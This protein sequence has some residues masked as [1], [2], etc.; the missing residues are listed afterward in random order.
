MWL[1]KVTS[2]GQITI[3]KEVRERLDLKEQDRV[4]FTVDD[5]GARLQVVRRPTVAGLAGRLAG[6]FPY[7]DLAE[8][9]HEVGLALGKARAEEETA[10]P[11]EP[12]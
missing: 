9:R 5:E 1:A 7:P 11:G 12:M 3:P 10:C 8:V 2:K 6:D 4:L